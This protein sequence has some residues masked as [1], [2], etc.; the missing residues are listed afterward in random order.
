MLCHTGSHIAF[1]S[2]TIKME[3][4]INNEGQHAS[5]YHKRAGRVN[6]VRIPFPDPLYDNLIVLHERSSS[7]SPMPDFVYGFSALR[8]QMIL[9]RL[10]RRTD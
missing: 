8:P 3:L 1:L 4:G 5:I 7:D 9:T 6:P 2:E 10:S